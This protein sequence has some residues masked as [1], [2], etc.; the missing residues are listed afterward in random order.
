MNQFE[1]LISRYGYRNQITELANSGVPYE[2]IR[3]MTAGEYLLELENSGDLKGHSLAEFRRDLASGVSPYDI[4]ERII[5]KF[6]APSGSITEEQIRKRRPLTMNQAIGKA[7]EATHGYNM[8]MATKAFKEANPD[9][10]FMEDMGTSL[11]GGIS[12]FAGLGV[13]G[14]SALLPD[15]YQE[16]GEKYAK[17]LDMYSASN[18][19]EFSTIEETN[20]PAE[21]AQAIINTGLARQTPMLAGIVGTSAVNPMAGLALT[22]AISLGDATG[23]QRKA[24]GD[25]DTMKALP[26]AGVSMFLDRMIPMRAVNALKGQTKEA[27]LKS[28]A[29][30]L[31]DE[32]YVKKTADEVAEMLNKKAPGLA[33]RMAGSGAIEAGTE[34]TQVFLAQMAVKAID[35]NHE[36]FSKDNQSQAFNEAVFS[37]LPGA[38]GGIPSGGKFEG[39]EIET[40]RKLQGTK[41]QPKQTQQP[42]ATQQQPQQPQQPQQAQ[43]QPQQAQSQPQQQQA[44]QPQAQGGKVELKNLT[45][46]K[47][48]SPYANYGN[49]TRSQA[50]PDKAKLEREVESLYN[51]LNA[52][53]GTD[54]EQELTDRFYEKFKELE[55]VTNLAHDPS[56]KKRSY[57]QRAKDTRDADVEIESG[58]QPYS[59][60]RP[61]QLSTEQRLEEMDRD[62]NPD[63]WNDDDLMFRV[64]DDPDDEIRP[65]HHN[66]IKDLVKE[67][68][69]LDD[70]DKLGFSRAL[71]ERIKNNPKKFYSLSEYQRDALNDIVNYHNSPRHVSVDA[72]VIPED[73]M[74]KMSSEYER[75]KTLKSGKPSRRRTAPTELE[76]N[77]P[78]GVA[79]QMP[80]RQGLKQLGNGKGDNAY[81]PPRGD[82]KKDEQ[83]A[84][85]KAEKIERNARAKAERDKV[86]AKGKANI[87]AIKA[88]AKAWER[89][90]IANKLAKGEANTQAE[91]DTFVSEIENEVVNGDPLTALD[92]LA[93]IPKPA[94]SKQARQINDL[95]KM[96]LSV[97]KAKAFPSGKLAKPRNQH[98]PQE[99]FED[100]IRGQLE[101]LEH[102]R[103]EL[104]NEDPGFDPMGRED[105]FAKIDAEEKRLREKYQLMTPLQLGK[106]IKKKG[107][108]RQKSKAKAIEVLVDHDL[109]MDSG[110]ESY[111][112][113]KKKSVKISDKRFK[114]IINGSDFESRVE[115]EA[116]N[117][118]SKPIDWGTDGKNDEKIYRHFEYRLSKAKTQ[119]DLFHIRTFF[120]DGDFNRA[121][122]KYAPDFKE[123]F[124]KLEH[125]LYKERREAKKSK[126]SETVSERSD[127]SPVN[128]GEAEPAGSKTEEQGERDVSEVSGQLSNN[129]K[130]LLQYLTRRLLEKD[131]PVVENGEVVEV[132]RDLDD[133]DMELEALE[134]K[135]QKGSLT[136]QHIIDSSFGKVMSTDELVL[137]DES[138]LSEVLK[139]IRLGVENVLKESSSGDVSEVSGVDEKL[140]KDKKALDVFVRYY[141]R[142][143]KKDNDF[144]RTPEQI[145]ADSER[146][147]KNLKGRIGDKDALKELLHIHNKASRKA[148]EVLTGIKLGLTNKSMEKAI[149]VAYPDG[150]KR[151]SENQAQKEERMENIFFG[152]TSSVHEFPDDITINE[153]IEFIKWNESR[154]SGY[155]KHS[156]GMSLKSLDLARMAISNLMRNLETKYSKSELSEFSKLYEDSD[157]RIRIMEREL[158]ISSV[159]SDK[160]EPS[161][162]QLK[163]EMKKRD[164]KKPRGAV[165][166]KEDMQKAIEEFDAPRKAQR[167]GVTHDVFKQVLSSKLQDWNQEFDDRFS[168]GGPVMD[169]APLSSFTIFKEG[170]RY[171]ALIGGGI[172]PRLS[173]EAKDLDSLVDNIVDES[174]WRMN[175]IYYLTEK[176]AFVSGGDASVYPTEVIPVMARAHGMNGDQIRE[177]KAK[178]KEMTDTRNMSN[179]KSNKAVSDAMVNIIAEAEKISGNI[180]P[181]KAPIFDKKKDEAK[182]GKNGESNADDGQSVSG[183]ADGSATGSS[184]RNDGGGARDS[185][186]GGRRNDADL[187]GRQPTQDDEADGKGKGNE[188]GTRPSS[189]GSRKGKPDKKQSPTDGK[190]IGAPTGDQGG[191][192]AG[193]GK[194]AGVEPKE[195]KEPQAQSRPNYHMKDPEAILGGSEEQRFENNKRALETLDDLESTGRQPTQ[196]DLDALAGY[197]GWGSF[198]QT[199][200]QGSYEKPVDRNGKKWEARAKWL[201]ERLP[202][203]EWE[204][205]Q[206]SIANAHYTDPITI[207]AVWDVLKHMGFDGGRIL[208]PSIGTGNFISMM[209]RDI[210]AKSMITGIE[211]DDTTAK[212]AKYLLPEANIQHKSYGESQ[213]SD[214]FYDLAIS[215]IPFGK[216]NLQRQGPRYSKF[217]TS[218]HNTYFVKAL[219]QVRPGGLVA[220]ITSKATMDGVKNQRM[221]NYMAKHADLVATFRM[222][223][224]AFKKYAGTDVVTDLVVFQKREVERMDISS[225]KSWMDVVEVEVPGGTVKISRILAENKDKLILGTLDFGNGTTNGRPGMIVNRPKESEYL[226]KLESVTDLFPNSKGIYKSREKKAFE[227]RY[228][229]NNSKDR[230][231]STTVENG[232]L[233]F[234]DGEHKKPLEEMVQW[235]GTSK[236]PEAIEEKKQAIIKAVDVRRKLGALIDAERAEAKDTEAKRKE[237]KQ[238]YGEFKKEFGA[239][240]KNTAIKKG[241][242][243]DPFLPSLLALEYK[244]NPKDTRE[245]WKPMP[246]MEQSATRGKP[247]LTNPSIGDAYAV[248]RNE[249]PSI[250][251]PEK[252]AEMSD[253]TV[254][255]VNGK[256]LGKSYFLDPTGVHYPSDVYLSGNVRRKLREAKEAKEQGM[257][258]DMNIKALES[259]I[260]QDV[261]HFNIEVGFGANWIP[262]DLY[263]EF[264]SK[265]MNS[266]IEKFNIRKGP[267][268]W[269][270]S[271]DSAIKSKPE[272]NSQWGTGRIS[273]PDILQKALN[274][275][276]I[277]IVDWVE[278]E[279]G[280]KTK[281]T[282]EEETSKANDKAVAIKEE[283][284][285]WLW[286]DPIRTVKMESLY[287]ETYN[288]TA[289]P[290][291]DG[292]HLTFEGMALNLGDSE[293]DLRQHQANA[294]WRGILTGRGI[295]AH[296]VGT[297]K[298]FTMATLAMESRRLGIS[299]KPLI[300]ALNANAK[301]IAVDFNRAYPSAKVLYVDSLGKKDR[302]RVMAQIALDDWDA[303]VAPHSLVDRFS[304]KPESVEALLGEQISELYLEAYDVIAEDGVDFDGKLEDIDEDDL[305]KLRS[306]T[307]KELVKEAQRLRGM[308]EKAHD[309]MKAGAM[310]FEDMGVDMVMVDESHQ[311]K[312]TPL[313]TKMRLKGLNPTGNAKTITLKLL[314]DYVRGINN[315]RGVH[316]FTGTPIT[317]TINEIYNKMSLTMP[318]IMKRDGIDG[319]D[320]FFNIFADRETN[321]ELTTGGTW[322]AVDRLSSFRNIPELRLMLGQYMD[323]VFTDDMPEFT[324]R[325]TREGLVPEGEKVVGVPFKEVVVDTGPM[326]RNQENIKLDLQDRYESFLRLTGKA[327]MEAIRSGDL[328]K[329]EDEGAKYPLDMRLIDPSFE[330]DPN[331]KVNRVVKNVLKH[332]EE[333]PK[334]TQMIFME[335]GYNDFAERTTGRGDNKSK[336]KVPTFNVAKEMKKKLVEGGYAEDEVVIFTGS[337]SKERRKEW[338]EKMRKGEVRVAI[339]AT[340]TLGTGINAQDYLRAMHHV[341]A[342]WMPG[343]LRQRNG[344]GERQGNRWNTVM[345]Y[346]YVTEKSHDGRRWQVLVTKDN[347]I[348]QF[349]RGTD[350]RVLEGDALDTSESG[351]DFT[352]TFSSA[353]GDNRILVRNKLENQVEKLQSAKNRHNQAIAKASNDIS[354]TENKLEAGTRIIKEFEVDQEIFEGMEDEPLISFQGKK[355]EKEEI[356]ELVAEFVEQNT[357]KGKI[358]NN[359]YLYSY[360]PFEVYANKI[361]LVENVQLEVKSPESGKQRQTNSPSHGSV[362]YYLRSFG[363]RIENYQNLQAEDRKSIESLKEMLGRPF[364]REDDLKNKMNQLAFIEREL[365]ASPAPAPTWMASTAPIGNQVFY[366]DKARDIVAHRWGEDD[367]IVA[368]QGD[369]GKIIEASYKEIK[370]DKG[371]RVY[372]DVQFA[373]PDGKVKEIEGGSNRMFADPERLSPLNS[374]LYSKSLSVDGDLNLD[375]DNNARIV[376]EV[377]DMMRQVK[378][379]DPKR[380]R[381]DKGTEEGTRGMANPDAQEIVIFYNQVDAQDIKDL[382]VH[383]DFVHLALKGIVGEKTYKMLL[384]RA[385]KEPKFA[386]LKQA[387]KKEYGNISERELA[388]E[389]LAHWYETQWRK[390]IKTPTWK[391]FINKVKLWFKRMFGKDTNLEN[392]EQIMGD[393]FRKYRDGRGPSGPKGGRRSRKNLLGPV[394]TN[395]K[396]FKE[397]FGDSK[398]VDEN[399]EPLVVY[400]GTKAPK[401]FDE[402]TL[403][404]ESGGKAFGE[405]FYFSDSGKVADKYTTRSNGW[406]H[407][408]KSHIKPVYLKITNPFVVED[409]IDFNEKVGYGING[410]KWLLENGYDGVI[411]NNPE[412]WG[413]PIGGRFFVA[414]KP[415]QIKSA[416]SNTGEF[417]KSNRDIRYS[418]D[419]GWDWL[420]GESESEESDGGSDFD[421]IEYDYD[422]ATLRDAVASNK[423]GKV[424]APVEEG[425]KVSVRLDLPSVTRKGI[426]TQTIHDKKIGPTISYRKNARLKNVEMVSREKSALKIKEGASKSPI[427]AVYGEFINDDIPPDMMSDWV[428]VKYNPKNHSY[429]YTADGKDTP[430]KSGEEAFL[431]GNSVYVKNPNYGDKGNYLYSKKLDPSVK[432]ALEATA[433]GKPAWPNWIRKAFP[434]AGAKADGDMPKWMEH[435]TTLSFKAHKLGGAMKEIM[436]IAMNRVNRRVDI[437]SE[438]MELITDYTNLD[439]KMRKKVD[440]L[441]YLGD[442]EGEDYR[443]SK[444]KDYLALSEDQ[445]KAYNGVRAM[446]EVTKMSILK[447]IRGEMETIRKLLPQEFDDLK[448]D[449]IV[450][451]SD[452][453]KTFIDRDLKKLED[454]KAKVIADLELIDFTPAK[455]E[456]QKRQVASLEK[457]I[458]RLRAQKK[459]LKGIIEE[460]IEKHD[461]INALKKNKGYFP[462]VRAKGQHVSYTD[463]LGEKYREVFEDNQSDE[464]DVAMNALIKDLNK[465]GISYEI[466]RVQDLPEEMFRTKSSD[467]VLTMMSQAMRETGKLDEKGL[468]TANEAIKTMFYSRGWR[469]HLLSREKQVI[470]GYQSKDLNEV[471]SQFIGGFAGLR[472][473]AESAR[474]YYKILQEIEPKKTPRIYDNAVKIIRDEL[475][476][477]DYT[478]RV[479]GFY[480]GVVYHALLGLRFSTAVINSTQ[481]FMLGVP[482]LGD[483]LRKIEDPRGFEADI[484]IKGAGSFAKAM[485]D[486]SM[487]LMGKNGA[488][489]EDEKAFLDLEINRIKKQN[490]TREQTEELFNQ[491]SKF[492]KAMAG[493]SHISSWM[494]QKTEDMNRIS[495]LLVYKRYFGK[496][497][498]T[499]SELKD[500]RKGAELFIQKIH[501]SYE[502]WN[503]L[504]AFKNP[505]MRLLEPFVYSLASYNQHLFQTLF[506]IDRRAKFAFA[507]SL[508]LLS[509]IPLEDLWE[510]A[511]I[512]FGDT[513]TR[514]HVGDNAGADFLLAG[515]PGMLGADLSGSLAM[516]MPPVVDLA[517]GLMGIENMNDGPFQSIVGNLSKLIAEGGDW[518]AF[519]NYFPML[520]VKSLIQGIHEYETGLTTRSGRPMTMDGDPIKRNEVS[521]IF[522]ALGVNTSDIGSIKKR[523]WRDKQLASKWSDKKSDLIDRYI[524]ADEKGKKAIMSEIK[525]FNRSVAKLRRKYKEGF[526]VALITSRSIKARRREV[527]VASYVS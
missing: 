298:T 398:V 490:L 361:A 433:D 251:Y 115:E 226:E 489:T 88:K 245:R 293:F 72:E 47:E 414:I 194:R 78:E 49:D 466:E 415:T 512:E 434:S 260:P 112:I 158:D 234:I 316:L 100:D 503:K 382:L 12:D 303:I 295:Y 442:L 445:R 505:T 325:K 116:F 401:G 45:G 362:M 131:I 75:I 128:V 159:E 395:S 25:I 385:L 208:E 342:P 149:E 482:V 343:E 307:A 156:K 154:Q 250:V 191:L 311:F 269:K 344:R 31:A 462:R 418:K 218:I 386:R 27:F 446:F 302:D 308:I 338:A 520:A 479:S 486:A 143:S 358:L 104:E 167:G 484:E 397:W 92:R 417:S 457:R 373:S 322:D 280:N 222:P 390:D 357:G 365:E 82:R 523:N 363:K 459:E 336:F 2:E 224:G 71:S 430:V 22:G 193:T 130:G 213:T 17:A 157:D 184:S 371:Q 453:G 148:F 219:D 202:K 518:D 513:H 173:F 456:E 277:T 499:D 281:V 471:L 375:D 272:A 13:R 57:A 274:N 507:V 236:K 138:D 119:S 372:S 23:E 321:I 228:I 142:L 319:W 30:N 3:D 500:L 81:A 477:A 87:K 214:N 337:V 197:A 300:Y 136:K 18:P 52:K 73:E 135:L 44:P 241:L 455:F 254:E 176:G 64:F 223:S 169:K 276:N 402:F 216:F 360:G 46:T 39:S 85:A 399:G 256:L 474:E 313:S 467:A 515:V 348:Q 76:S 182:I 174:T 496:D 58:E 229:T 333:H 122:S 123:R 391:A 89:Q 349:M 334:A 369:N 83:D 380:I 364:G 514:R 230:Q 141:T 32:K 323:V 168:F 60:N 451:V 315:G 147:L 62:I 480:K 237:L 36:V 350:K 458:D 238:A 161:V 6:S 282:N 447:D 495:A 84:R 488:L 188:A 309:Q 289:I 410:T 198:G 186:T 125:Q 181:K 314:T 356:A 452:N 327:K 510:K 43:T 105:E 473:K 152:G 68:N 248:L 26:F 178:W 326:S 205:A 422:E 291:Y 227:E 460:L 431:V 284:K 91:I 476:N 492:G 335:K 108:P 15:E 306:P 352:E 129:D 111:S 171:T 7:R 179:K 51:E 519:R 261:D 521:A 220:F 388:D 144:N 195:K 379:L 493:A 221:K 200:F 292:S 278:D 497:K 366:K 54:E 419:L 377:L 392:L 394:D 393:A 145:Q 20:G 24:T 354:S 258:M 416:I 162:A 450:K 243:F 225:E 475:R 140:N 177:L 408:P 240:N 478:D 8:A 310:F 498:K 41:N 383:E 263:L 172:S 96:A 421:F 454:E 301:E 59:I 400:H 324:P 210:H 204:S 215:N 74:N 203:E 1:D 396:A 14:I 253:K 70:N 463:E 165:W 268:G 424:N 527:K 42:Q 163:K 56:V 526:R 63:P 288:N 413:S 384:H 404:F 244:N 120:D 464:G 438:L 139:Y 133:L 53:R 285:D 153:A 427:G 524:S 66:A 444:H 67:F 151:E 267:A 110:F 448:I 283:F 305:K 252:I 4:T 355:V 381:F 465:R 164:I 428:E 118:Y 509:G 472:S 97:A 146:M 481:N 175:D 287:N 508:T 485:K 407:A 211:Y 170:N 487:Y 155:K 209:P 166:G 389:I 483:E 351:G 38:L 9:P 449:E 374:R 330:D 190:H 502:K 231:F 264:S 359:E 192:D 69:N 94:N 249:S 435:L 35:E 265:L 270:V 347:F 201:R 101:D 491:S 299:K 19:S 405:G 262:K 312:K 275:Q 411:V 437:K 207:K 114:E 511:L 420:T 318:D 29:K 106:E 196:E 406:E 279:N 93:D 99:I 28:F 86:I 21:F 368:L 103:N 137:L 102:R 501:F 34:A 80:E 517:M 10:T 257:D 206:T 246:I 183:R 346:R 328:L 409:Q 506:S 259:V 235:W 266:D 469:K 124:A 187:L 232:E 412:V 273:F 461:H 426:Y 367:F 40:L 522:K 16:A 180:A 516:N 134:R 233:F 160:K 212:I 317:N 247:K 429:F 90:I 286:S 387:I 425:R 199:L 443:G 107:L 50:T 370:N 296:E 290:S 345:E 331:S 185:S 525:E 376:D 494:F 242:K 423:A 340:S 239:I 37:F 353:T 441:L 189:T 48:K 79:R 255:E 5:D 339:G 504:D 121:I 436:E 294:V 61:R 378:G 126:E 55:E 470:H 329:I 11:K 132:R 150:A 98:G 297:G 468:E 33:R 271:A 304:L 127:E 109:E 432:M 65:I 332:K 117:E 217:N 440:D 113:D 95:G 439:P 320:D 341:D 403:D 77:L